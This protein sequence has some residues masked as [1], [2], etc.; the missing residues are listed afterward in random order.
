MSMILWK[1]MGI[2]MV[3]AEALSIRTMT[4]AIFFL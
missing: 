1:K 2:I 4:P 3:S